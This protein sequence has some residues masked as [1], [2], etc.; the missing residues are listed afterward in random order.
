MPIEFQYERVRAVAEGFEQR[1][2]FDHAVEFIAVQDQQTAAVGG[3]VDRLAT[4]LDVAEHE[5]VVV[6]KDVVVVTRDVDDARAVP[7]LAE[8]R[9]DDVVVRLRPEERSAQTP[10]SMMSPTR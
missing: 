2:R 6:A 1:A 5:A 8:N 10:T 3:L 7:G 9:A 4:N